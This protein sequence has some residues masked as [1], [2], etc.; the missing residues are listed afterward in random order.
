MNGYYIATPNKD[1]SMIVQKRLFEL[2]CKW[3]KKPRQKPKASPDV[4]A[5]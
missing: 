4:Y 1:L 3:A 2:D 5:Q